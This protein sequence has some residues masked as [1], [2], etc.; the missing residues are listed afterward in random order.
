MVDR[1]TKCG[2]RQKRSSEANRRY[3]LLLHTLASKL[4]PDGDEYSDE[5]YHVYYKL[6]FLG[7]DDVKMPNG[8]VIAV[9]KS[10]AELDK[11]EFHE[12]AFM[13]E[14]D[15]NERGVYLDEMVPE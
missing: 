2:R 11:A 8:K 13:V 1:C 12:Y 10:T 7:A 6:K 15:A 4:E 9:P 5:T 14:H 3:W